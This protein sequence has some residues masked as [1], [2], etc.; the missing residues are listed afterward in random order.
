MD[1]PQTEKIYFKAKT[2]S[3]I[4]LVFSDEWKLPDWVS[5]SAEVLKF[6]PDGTPP[7]APA[8]RQVLTSKQVREGGEQPGHT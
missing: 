6:T 3:S 1:K 8:K 2:P 7:I 5:D 4:T